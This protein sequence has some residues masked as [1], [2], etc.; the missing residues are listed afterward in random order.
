M[1]SCHRLNSWNLGVHFRLK[2]SN[3]DCNEDVKNGLCNVSISETPRLQRGLPDV[4]SSPNHL[5][6]DLAEGILKWSSPVEHRIITGLNLNVR[7]TEDPR[8]GGRKV[9]FGQSKAS[10]TGDLTPPRGSEEWHG[11]G[12]IAARKRHSTIT[13]IEDE[14][15]V[16]LVRLKVTSHSTDLSDEGWVANIVRS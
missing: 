5:N 6:Q 15:N 16:T 1:R 4:P 3:K 14:D 2:R 13:K 10:K 7:R 11:G 8:G 9:L 12:C